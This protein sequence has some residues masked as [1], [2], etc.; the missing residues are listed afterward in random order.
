MIAFLVFI[1]SQFSAL[2][3]S[4]SVPQL[5]MYSMFS[6][7]SIVSTFSHVYVIVLAIII[8]IHIYPV[9]SPWGILYFSYLIYI[10]VYLF[11]CLYIRISLGVLIPS[12]T[13]L[14][15]LII[16]PLSEFAVFWMHSFLNCSLICFVS[17]TSS[18]NSDIQVIEIVRLINVKCSQIF[19]FSCQLY[20]YT[21]FSHSCRLTIITSTAVVFSHLQT[22]LTSTSY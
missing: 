12:Y 22:T 2:C 19:I 21:F 17:F 15:Y 7:Q 6:P 11:S 14:S 18:Q 1:Y 5:K 20:I 3:T 13:P 16:S 9:F 10:I 8:F 4:T